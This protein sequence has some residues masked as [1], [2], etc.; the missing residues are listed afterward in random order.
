MKY[1]YEVKLKAIFSRTLTSSADSKEEIEEATKMSIPDGVWQSVLE[2]KKGIVED[3]HFT[4]TI[5]K[6]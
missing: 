5:Q 1:K 4:M 3:E 2:G 6:L